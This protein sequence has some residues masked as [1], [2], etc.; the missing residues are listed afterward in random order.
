MTLSAA[1]RLKPEI[2]LAQAISEFEST[3][4][5]AQKADFRGWRVEALKHPPDTTD[6]MRFTADIDRRI[7]KGNRCLGPRFTSFLSTV[8]QFAALGDVVVGSSQNIIACGV[9]S[10]VRMSILVRT[11]FFH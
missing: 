9:W 2:R 11:Y 1:A 10:L 5:S 4:S 6:V 8:Q 3:L 7:A